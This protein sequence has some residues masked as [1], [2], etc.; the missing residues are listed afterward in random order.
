MSFCSVFADLYGID[1]CARK[2]LPSK[3][4]NGLNAAHDSD[5]LLDKQGSL[6]AAR[7]VSSNASSR[8]LAH[9]SAGGLARHV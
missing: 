3:I 2:E 5:S 8:L 7:N 9:V 1:G 6:E 4:G